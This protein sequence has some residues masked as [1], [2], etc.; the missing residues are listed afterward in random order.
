MSSLLFTNARILSPTQEARALLIDGDRIL[1]LDERDAREDTRRIDCGGRTIVPGFVDAHGHL[2][3]YAASLLS[4]DCRGIPDIA[5]L[6]TR[7]RA[8]TSLA[9]KGAWVRAAGYDENDLAERRHPTRR[10]LDDA[11]PDHPVRLLHRSGH[12]EVLN[13]SALAACG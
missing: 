1:S 8:A 10:D 5:T 9:P 12:A 7:I 4:V 11:A 2:L 3:A 6:Q 13:S